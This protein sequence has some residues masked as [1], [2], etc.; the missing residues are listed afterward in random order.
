MC[1][2]NTRFIVI[3]FEYILCVLFFSIHKAQTISASNGKT[4]TNS[5]SK[6]G[7]TK[8]RIKVVTKTPTNTEP[9][10]NFKLEK[11]QH[12]NNTT[13]TKVGP[14][15]TQIIKNPKKCKKKIPQGINKT[16]S[17]VV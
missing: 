3:I 7:E 15:T 17:M 1:S 13:I 16:A 11:R 4:T 14:P 5:K 10:L 12:H 9:H 6:E 2:K 8:R